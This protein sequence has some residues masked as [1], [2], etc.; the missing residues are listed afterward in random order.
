MPVSLETACWVRRRSCRARTS[1]R[2]SRKAA[3]R[4]FKRSIARG[5]RARALDSMPRQNCLK[6]GIDL[7]LIP[8]GYVLNNIASTRRFPSPLRL[9]LAARAPVSQT[10]LRQCDLLLLPLFRDVLAFVVCAEQQDDLVAVRVTENPVLDLDSLH[11]PSRRRL[12]SA[13]PRFIDPCLRSS[14][15]AKLEQ[16]ISELP[17]EARPADIPVR[18]LAESRASP[19]QRARRL[20]L[21]TLGSASDGQARRRRASGTT[22]FCSLAARVLVKR[23]YHPGGSRVAIRVATAKQG[24]R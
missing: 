16:T 24:M 10:V 20:R 8:K 12:S 17:P 13:P 1:S 7:L 6:V 22:R 9:S 14:I 21:T 11:D 18:P 2:A 23:L 19:P 4:S 5:P 3:L 15:E